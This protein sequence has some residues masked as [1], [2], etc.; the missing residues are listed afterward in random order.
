MLCLICG[1][2]HSLFL[3]Y[4]VNNLLIQQLLERTSNKTLLKFL[5]SDLSGI[6]PSVG[7]KLIE[8]LGSSFD[9]DMGPDELDDKQITRLVQVLRST[10]DLFKSPD[11]GCLSP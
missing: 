4:Q 7:K 3:F 1:N 6:S 10:D 8:R 5:T 9:E 2:M 11:G